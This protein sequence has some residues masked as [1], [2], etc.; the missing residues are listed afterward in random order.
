M[1]LT[2]TPAYIATV[3][4]D[5]TIVLP[6]EIPIGA[7]VIITV[8]PAVQNQSDDQAYSTPFATTLAAI[9]A[10]ANMPTPPAISDAELDA[11][12]KKARRASYS[13]S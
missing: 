3:G 7:Q 1:P 8:V 2:S 13:H 5:R 10:A 6:A 9:R 12:I 11:L 4:E